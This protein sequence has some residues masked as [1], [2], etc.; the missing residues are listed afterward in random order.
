M[1]ALEHYLDPAFPEKHPLGGENGESKPS[2]MSH[3]ALCR[4]C[5]ALA[6]ASRLDRY[7][8]QSIIRRRTS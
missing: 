5:G 2:A 3:R 7:E 8:Y 6:R 4:F 1:L